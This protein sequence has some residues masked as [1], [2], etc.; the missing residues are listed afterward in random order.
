MDV[1]QGLV[2]LVYEYIASDELNVPDLSDSY[3]EKRV[4]DRYKGVRIKALS[5][6]NLTRRDAVEVGLDDVFWLEARGLKI[7]KDIIP[8][9]SP[10]YPIESLDEDA[11]LFMCVHMA[12]MKLQA[13]DVPNNLNGNFK[14]S[15]YLALAALLELM[16][17]ENLLNLAHADKANQNKHIIGAISELLFASQKVEMINDFVL[18]HSAREMWAL[19]YDSKESV[20]KNYVNALEDELKSRILKSKRKADITNKFV[21]NS[22]DYC[23]NEAS[24]IWE[25]QTS[26]NLEIQRIGEISDLL[27][28]DLDVNKFWRPKTAEGVASWLR[29]AAREGELTIP[30]EARKPGRPRNPPV[31]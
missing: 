13:S 6:I 20:Y 22:K 23:I 17:C 31:R 18:N 11:E 19:E 15:Q 26:N 2:D 24:Q 4:I 10:D 29:D 27:W 9:I 28:K 3:C 16:L 8:R 5:L 14:V 30:Q 21:N 1:S 12:V 7:F 25:N